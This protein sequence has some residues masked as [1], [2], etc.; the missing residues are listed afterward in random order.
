M[1]LIPAPNNNGWICPNDPGEPGRNLPRWSVGDREAR[2]VSEL[3]R[4]LIVL[5]IGTGLGV[6]T[7]EIAKRAKF[8]YTVD[9]DP[10]VKENIAPTLPENV[11]FFQER[12]DVPGKVDA[13][14]IDGFHSFEQCGKDILFVRKL[15]RP[16]GLIV[17]HDLYIA[18]IKEA[19]IKSGLEGAEIRTPCGIAITWNE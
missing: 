9:I 16:G 18:G 1:K 3:M 11:Q 12:K 13:A 7:K 17:F 4:G 14:F 5:E 6:S 2:I 10:W 15:V 8:V 19:I